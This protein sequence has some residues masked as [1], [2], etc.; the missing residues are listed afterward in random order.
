MLGIRWGR[1]AQCKFS[2]IN[3]FMQTHIPSLPSEVDEKSSL[4]SMLKKPMV[5]FVIGH[6]FEVTKSKVTHSPHNTNAIVV[7]MCVCDQRTV[8]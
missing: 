7:C 1:W 5:T 8:W 2:K 3:A 6:W 4:K